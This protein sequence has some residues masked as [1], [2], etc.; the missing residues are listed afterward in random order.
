MNSTSDPSASSISFVLV[1]TTHAGNIGAAARAM[2]TMGFSSLRL[3][4]PCK[5]RTAEALARASGADDIVHSAEVF[6][7]LAEAVADCHQ[8]YGTSARSRSLEWAVVSAREAASQIAET[9]AVKSR[10][11][12]VF[13][14]ERSGLTNEELDLCHHRLWI[15]TNPDFGSLNLG[16][17][18]QV[19]AYELAMAMSL[20]QK[21]NDSKATE[22][23]P[24]TEEPTD[25]PADGAAMEHFYQHLEQTLIDTEFLDPDNPRLLLRRLRRYFGRSQPSVTEL[26]ILRGILTSIN[27]STS[28]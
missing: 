28:P 12:M 6:G 19:V 20:N 1:N 25:S 16:S 11:A 5:F 26:N 17:A 9:V 21:L 10:T 22:H 23:N 2:K 18:V 3:V 4:E 13:G 7:T 15:P 14:R 24:A 8:V 27:K